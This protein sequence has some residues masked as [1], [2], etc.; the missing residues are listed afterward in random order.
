MKRILFLVPLLSLMTCGI[1]AQWKP[2]GNRIKT[3]W[4]NKVNPNEVL[5][6]YPRPIMERKDWKNLNGIWKYAIIQKGDRVPDKFDGEILVP[7]AIESSLSGVCKRIDEKQ[8]L[9]YLREF[10]IPS[11]WKDKKILLHFGAVDWETSVWIN[12]VKVG[13][14]T[15]GFT[16]FSFDITPALL[17]KGK[18]KLKVKVWDPTDK[19]TQPRGKQVSNPEGIWYSPVSGIWQTVWLEPVAEKHISNLRI[20]PDGKYKV[21]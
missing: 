10:D 2:I 13:H 12:D 4:A 3:K 19:G 9:V 7:F 21:T 18:N 8:E 5:P 1:Q 15:G 14:H 16:P 20:T 11:A 6:E 17:L